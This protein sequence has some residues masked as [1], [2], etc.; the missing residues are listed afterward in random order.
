MHFW[1]QILNDFYSFNC[2][3]QADEN[4]SVQPNDE[5]SEDKPKPKIDVL[6]LPALN[7][8]ESDSSDSESDN[9]NQPTNELNEECG[10]REEQNVEDESLLI[11]NN[12]DLERDSFENR[13]TSEK[14]IDQ[15]NE[16]QVDVLVKQN[17]DVESSNSVIQNI[18]DNFK[19]YQA[20]KEKLDNLFTEVDKSEE[21]VEEPEEPEVPS[22]VLTLGIVLRDHDYCF[23]PEQKTDCNIIE[24]RERLTFSSYSLFLKF[25][26]GLIIYYVEVFGLY[27]DLAVT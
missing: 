10:E 19:N 2:V 16:N 22:E 15:S 5:N 8:S 6:D 18:W 4:D 27:V 20:N 11:N 23:I 9:I 21:L 26:W 25:L 13:G 17:E 24:V 12:I 1:V 7:L 14:T 3:V